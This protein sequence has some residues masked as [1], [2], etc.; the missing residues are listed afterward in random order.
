MSQPDIPQEQGEQGSG[1]DELGRFAEG[2]SG[3]PNG[4]PKGVKTVLELS[5]NILDED[6][7]RARRLAETWLNYLEEN[8]KASEIGLLF[9]RQDGRVSQPVDMKHQMPSLSLRDR[10]R[11]DPRL[12]P[13]VL[14]I[15]EAEQS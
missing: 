8:P 3:N 13:E 2:N 9:D 10:T 11:V 5:K 4:R 6:Q 1:R 12:P 7:D 14:E 15:D